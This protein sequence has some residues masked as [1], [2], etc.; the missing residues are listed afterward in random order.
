MLEAASVILPVDLSM[1]AVTSERWPR[2]SW[3]VSSESATF[4]TPRW[5]S[6]SAAFQDSTPPQTPR[7]VKPRSSRMRPRRPLVHR[8]TH[9][10]Q[11]RR[12]QQLRHARQMR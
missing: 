11:H 7:S 10:Q 2:K 9:L 12:Q 1:S 5:S 4:D 3:S 8:S 6:T